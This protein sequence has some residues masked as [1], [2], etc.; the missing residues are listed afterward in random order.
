MGE[1]GKY[2]HAVFNVFFFFLEDLSSGPFS[3]PEE[4][5]EAERM[6]AV[7]LKNYQQV[8]KK[9]INQQNAIFISTRWVHSF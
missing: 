3:L 7:W 1:S 8:I 2:G 5:T 4:N 6:V 9:R